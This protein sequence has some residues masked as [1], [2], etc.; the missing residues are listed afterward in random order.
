LTERSH[1]T[2]FGMAAGRPKASACRQCRPRARAHAPPDGLHSEPSTSGGR[3]HLLR[4]LRRHLRRRTRDPP[5]LSSSASRR[6]DRIHRANARDR[7]PCRDF[8]SSSTPA[9]RDRVHVCD[10]LQRHLST[11]FVDEP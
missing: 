9:R 1:R 6:P 3:A 4:L 2:R 11:R 8:N 10:R 7:T 5:T